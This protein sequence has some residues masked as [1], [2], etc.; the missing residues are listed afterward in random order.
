MMLTSLFLLLIIII[1][2]IFPEPSHIHFS[3]RDPSFNEKSFLEEKRPA[4][5]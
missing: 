1:I 3:I 5:K 4:G 2:I